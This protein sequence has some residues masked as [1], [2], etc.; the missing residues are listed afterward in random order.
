[1]PTFPFVGIEEQYKI[2]IPTSSIFAIGGKKSLWSPNGNTVS[3]AILIFFIYYSQ[4]LYG[5]Y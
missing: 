3:Q 2:V 1:M 5:L 4:V